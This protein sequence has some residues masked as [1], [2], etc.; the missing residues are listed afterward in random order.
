MCSGKIHA[1]SLGSWVVGSA[2]I[3]R[4]GSSA[5][6]ESYGYVVLALRRINKRYYAIH[7]VCTRLYITQHQN[8][9]GWGMETTLGRMLVCPPPRAV[10]IRRGWPSGGWRRVLGCRFLDGR[11]RLDLQLPLR[12]CDLGRPSEV[13]R[14]GLDLSCFKSS[15][16][17]YDPLVSIVYR[18][19]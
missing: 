15:T 10:A 16:W 1:I 13:Q 19:G 11:W 8:L 6:A 9:W 2:R 14:T 12:G 5:A 7:L 18:F 3:T 17:I 4:R